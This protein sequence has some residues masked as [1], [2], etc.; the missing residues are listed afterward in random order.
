MYIVG[1]W[2]MNTLPAESVDLAGSIIELTDGL[3]ANILI[4]PPLTSTAAV[5]ECCKNTEVKVGAQNVHWEDS[6]AYTGEVSARMLQQLGVQ[7]VIVGHSERRQ[8]FGETLQSAAD[9]AH[10]AIKSNLQ[11]IF[12]IGETEAE[13]NQGKTNQILNDQLEPLANCLSSINSK[14]F[15][16]AYEPVWAIGTGKSASIDDI[17]QAHDFIK[18]WFKDRKAFVP[19]V[20]YGGSVKPENFGEI[21]ALDNVDGALIGGASLK[22]ESFS[23]IAKI[24]SG[25][26]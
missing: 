10:A 3:A 23:E 17:H 1:N 13:R 21:S 18:T 14:N 20:L 26:S 2:K 8:F 6:G 16:L 22:A 11:A 9:R 4:A 7:F 24:G 25:A 12:C 19:S 5:L 15:M